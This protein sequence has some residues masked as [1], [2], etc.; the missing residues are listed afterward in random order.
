MTISIVKYYLKQKYASIF[1]SRK[2]QFKNCKANQI[3][4]E[5]RKSDAIEPSYH[6]DDLDCFYEDFIFD[7]E[8]QEN[9]FKISPLK[10]N[11]FRM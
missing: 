6:D 9:D 2:E 7:E 5:K 8:F 4:S 3:E 11:N 10:T 1:S